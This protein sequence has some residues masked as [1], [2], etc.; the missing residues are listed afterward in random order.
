MTDASNWAKGLADKKLSERGKKRADQDKVLSDRNLVKARGPQMWEQFK[1][2]VVARLGELK[3]AMEG[4]DAITLRQDL[5]SARL[6]IHDAKSGR[7]IIGMPFHSEYGA[8]PTLW[9]EFV[10]EPI[11]TNDVVW[12][13]KKSYTRWTSEELSRHLVQKAFEQVS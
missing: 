1:N 4:E 10:L 11:G 6:S 9:G 5:A 2:E 13:E 3:F 12:R 7:E 8:M